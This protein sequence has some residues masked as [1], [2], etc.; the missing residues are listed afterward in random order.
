MNPI[1]AAVCRRNRTIALRRP[2]KSLNAQTNARGK[3][4]DDAVADPDWV[5]ATRRV[6]AAMPAG[7]RG[8]GPGRGAAHGHAGVWQM[9]SPSPAPVT[10]G[11]FTALAHA[12]ASSAI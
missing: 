6:L 3:S 9:S 5:E 4:G 8:G 12:W 7:L 1:T 2:L 10:R 11:T